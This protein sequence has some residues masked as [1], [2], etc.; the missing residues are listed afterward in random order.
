MY[1]KVLSSD[2]LPSLKTFPVVEI[3][4][5]S[6]IETETESGKESNGDIDISVVVISNVYYSDWGSKWNSIAQVSDHC[7]YIYL[8]YNFS[9][10]WFIRRRWN[11]LIVKEI[12][13]STFPVVINYWHCHSLLKSYRLLALAVTTF[14]TAIVC[15]NVP[16]IDHLLPWSITTFP[17]M[18]NYC[19]CLSQCSL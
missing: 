9:F 14:P 1:V 19:H 4:R 2:K 15:H 16:S 5:I 17:V 7:L 18:I 3:L 13:M 10:L 8:L 11:I 6:L 12:L